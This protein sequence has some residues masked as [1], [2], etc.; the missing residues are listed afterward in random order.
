MRSTLPH[1]CTGLR[2]RSMLRFAQRGFVLPIALILIAIMLVVVVTALRWSGL[3]QTIAGNLR[4][5]EIA[6]QAAETGLKACEL[7]LKETYSESSAGNSNRSTAYGAY[8]YDSYVVDPDPFPRVGTQ[9]YW[10][11]PANWALHSVTASGMANEYK[12][13]LQGEYG[14]DSSTYYTLNS[15]VQAPRCII[16]KVPLPPSTTEESVQNTASYRITARGAGARG[17]AQSPTTVVFLQ[18]MIRI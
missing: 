3:E 17:T 12:G 16:E 7:R 4:D 9:Y 14:A 18:A 10:E 5:Q 6:T 8:S 15:A 1:R 13:P 2:N 11:N